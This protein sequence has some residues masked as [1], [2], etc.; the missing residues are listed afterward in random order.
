VQYAVAACYPAG[1]ALASNHRV[2]WSRLTAGAMLVLALR[3]RV[4]CNE[5]PS[6]ISL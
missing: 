5:R 4:L 6:H 2:Y 1:V 3:L